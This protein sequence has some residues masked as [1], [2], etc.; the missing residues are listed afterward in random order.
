MR[1]ARFVAGQISTV[2]SFAVEELL[3]DRVA[4]LMLSKPSEVA[5]NGDST[6]AGTESMESSKESIQKVPE[7][8]SDSGGNKSESRGR[9]KADGSAQNRLKTVVPKT[10]FSRL[11]T[12]KARSAEPAARNMTVETET[13]SSIPQA[14]IPSGQGDRSANGG[15]DGN[16][17]IRLKPSSETIRP[18]KDRKRSVRKTPSV[19]SGTGESRRN[20]PARCVL[21][22]VLELPDLAIAKPNIQPNK[23]PTH[24]STT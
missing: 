21:A 6:P 15:G 18:K 1:F 11:Q 20:L 5:R 13:V 16:A 19:A 10:S 23:W 7:S 12:A 17:T 9:R 14:T 24:S 2:F 4:R 22:T 3:A 8:G